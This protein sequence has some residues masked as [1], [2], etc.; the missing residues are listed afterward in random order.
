MYVEIIDNFLAPEVLK[1]V[2]R[3]AEN[4]KW[5]KTFTRAGSHMLEHN[6]IV[7]CP[8]MSTLYLHFSTP[9][10]LQ[11]LERK[12]DIK[13]II[14]DPHMIGAGYSE[15]RNHGDLKPHI[16]FNWNDTI[17]MHRI[18]TLIIYLN[19]GYT[20]GELQF[21][22]RPPIIPMPNRAVIFQHHETIRHMVTPVKGTRRALRYFYYASKL[23]PPSGYHRA[24]YGM[25]DNRPIDVEGT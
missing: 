20:G 21:D 5:D 25:K 6:D 12:M 9:A 14:S 7:N 2:N 18:A 10:F 23:E 4:V 24:L 11:R 3:E 17:K 16:D 15:M 22:N 13:G 8:M 19:G 1:L